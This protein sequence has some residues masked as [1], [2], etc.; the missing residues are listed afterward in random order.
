MI[1]SHLGEYQLRRLPQS[2]PAT[3][4]SRREPM[5]VRVFFF[6][7]QKNFPPVFRCFQANPSG[8]P[9]QLPYHKGAMGWCDFQ[10]C[11]A[12]KQKQNPNFQALRSAH[13]PSA[14]VQS[15]AMSLSGR[16]VSRVSVTEGVCE[17]KKRQAVAVFHICRFRI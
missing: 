7:P 10:L 16:K 9:R 15:V 14:A 6:V 1:V 5:F 3:A 17:T 4:P 8:A 12:K 2:P 11:A 13:F